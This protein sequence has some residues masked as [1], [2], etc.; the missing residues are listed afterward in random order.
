MKKA[1]RAMAFF[2]N[3]DALFRQ[4]R[5]RAL[6]KSGAKQ[7]KHTFQWRGC[8]KDAACFNGLL[9]NR[10]RERDGF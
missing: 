7:E 5:K 6:S 1:I 3:R 10:Q 8:N 9:E 2:G 4:N